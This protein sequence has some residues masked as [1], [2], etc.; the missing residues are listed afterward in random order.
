M[1]PYERYHCH[2]S[3]VSLQVSQSH[4]GLAHDLAVAR[5]RRLHFRFQ[6]NS[7]VRRLAEHQRFVA[8]QLVSQGHKYRFHVVT[9][10]GVLGGGLKQRHTVCVGKL[11]GQVC[12]HLDGASQVTLVSDQDARYVACQQVL[13]AL[14]YPG[15][16]A[17]EAGHVRHVIHEDDSVHVPVVVLDHALPEALLPR[18]VPQLDLDA[19][20]VDLHGSLPKVHPDRGLGAVGEA[21]GAEAVSQARLAHV[22][23]ADHYD[24][25]NAG[26]GGRQTPGRP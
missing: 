11:L 6:A 26:A 9:V 14:L 21:A 17:V 5:H 23:V 3:E 7:A 4:D 20:A 8:L 1:Y 19:L 18:G 15:R 12:G 16:Q 10:I 2:T 13:L 22:R 25:E 24:L